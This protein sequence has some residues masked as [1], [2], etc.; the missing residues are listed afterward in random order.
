MIVFQSIDELRER[1][2][3]NSTRRWPSDSR[4]TAPSV[5]S[6]KTAEPPGGAGGGGQGRFVVQQ[7]DARNLHWDL[8]LEHEGVLVSWALPR[9]IPEHPDENRLAVHTEDHPLEYLDFHGR[10]PEGRVRR[11]HDGDLGQ[12]HLRGR[13]VPRRRGDRD[14]PGRAAAGPL[15]AV[16]HARQGLADPPH[17]PAGGPRLRADAGP[18]RAD[19][20][21][22][23]RAAPRRGEMGLRGQVGRHPHGRLPRP[24]PHLAAGTQLH[25]LHAALSRGARAGARAGR[26]ARDPR[27]RD[28]RVRRR[29]PAELRA[30]PDAHAPR[31]RLGGEAPRCAT[32]RSPTSPSTC[33]TST[34]TRRSRSPTSSAA[35]CWRRSSWRGRRGARPPTT[36]ARARPCS[37]PRA[38]WASRASSPS[39]STRPTSPAGAAP[40]WLKIKN[41][42]EQDV[43]IGGWTPGEGGRSSDAGRA[44]RRRDGRRQAD[45]RRQGGHGLHRAD[46]APWCSASWSRCGATPRRSSGASRRR[47]RFSWSRGWSR[48]S[49]CANGLAAER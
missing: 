35:S 47:A 12:R 46:A 41:V 15:R 5:T 39:G 45:L 1:R 40:R 27:R 9:G 38:S 30:P 16:L 19:A 43:V 10:D 44:G 13:E 23:R 33:S 48:A 22:A 36:A 17:G 24:R 28:R 20:G 7:H 37:T 18:P 34:A 21:P 25:G 42:C 26:A 4:P 14:V 11:R 31:L 49:S 29:G 8:R 2:R 6:S 3:R 32:R